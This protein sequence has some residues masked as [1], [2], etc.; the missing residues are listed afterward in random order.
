VVV[1]IL[2]TKQIEVSWKAAPEPDVVG[3]RIEVAEVT[4]ASDDEL[5]RLK[6]RTPPLEVPSVGA[7]R[8]VTPFFRA[9]PDPVNGTSCVLEAKLPQHF[10]GKPLYFREFH[11][12]EHDP[13]GKPVPIDVYAF[14]VRAVNALGV[15][16][17]PSAAVVSIPSSPQGLFAK[18]EGTTCHLK[19][20]AN[21]EK[22]I[23]GYRVYRMDGRFDKEPVTRLTPEP[24]QELKFSDP[25]AGKK[26]RRYYVVAVDALGQE[27]YPSSPVWFDREWKSYYKPFTGDWHQ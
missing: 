4:V 9:P 20:S 3:Y 18:E 16:S 6:S 17:G 22:G 11:K 1:S 15:E 26:S 19:W 21:P 8:A 12:E 25:E 10:E 7:L 13:K 24:I 14:R 2:D 23:K 27:G 5:T